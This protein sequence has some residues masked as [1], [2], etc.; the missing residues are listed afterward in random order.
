MY[1]NKYSG[2]LFSGIFTFHL[3]LNPVHAGV[4]TTYTSESDT[5]RTTLN[6][7]IP[8][9]LTSNLLTKQRSKDAAL[10]L[11]EQARLEQ[12]NLDYEQSI[13][14][15][16]KVFELLNKQKNKATVSASRLGFKA[17][18]V[19]SNDTVMPYI[20]PPYE[21]VLAHI[22]QAK[23]YISV[24]DM[25][26]AAVEMRI[27]QQ[28]QRDIE[29]EHEKEL[30]KKS[31]KENK[32]ID[33][34]NS[35]ILNDAFSGLDPIAGKIKNTYQN[36]YAFYMA[37]SL[38]EVLGEY[39][40]ALVDYKKAYELQPDKQIYQDIER[41]D[42]LS[43]SKSSR[44][45][46]VIIFIEQGLVPQ[47]IE[48]KLAIPV[49]NGI[50]NIAYATYEPST[51]IN[52]HAV[53][54]LINSKKQKNSYVLNDIGALAVK[55]L[56]EQT[57][58]NVS[59]QIIRTTTKFVAQKQLGDQLGVFGQLAGNIMNIASERADLRSW[60]TLPSNT[61]IARLSLTPG[62]HDLQLQNNG[63]YSQPLTLNVNANQTIFVYAYDIN[64]KITMSS[65]TI[66]SP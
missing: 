37:A 66:P 63:I 62:K 21:Q 7:N 15:Y 3:F 58:N 14:T 23:N 41:V 22:S 43:S 20:V 34:E 46:P 52:P 25:E 5:F 40:D 27:A 64:R 8:S 28:L 4:F 30:A 56:K 9:E 61:Q 59:T 24:H 17:L 11:L 57:F 16:N 19:L 51:Y 53:D 45:V 29:L 47:K 35:K 48:N 39:N 18:S 33:N 49:P 50:I 54:I 36:S 42:K 44:E 55:Q 60:S 13:E 38:W 31:E 2:I 32:Q 10:Y 26:K 6:Q 65:S 12:V 1:I